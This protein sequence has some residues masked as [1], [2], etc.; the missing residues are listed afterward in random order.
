[1]APAQ[2]RADT[3]QQNERQE[4]RAVDDI[5]EGGGDADALSSDDFA[6]HGEEGAPE[7]GEGDAEDEPWK[8]SVPVPPDGL[9]SPWDAGQAVERPRIALLPIG[10]VVRNARNRKHGDVPSDAREMLHNLLTGR[11]QDAVSRAIDDLLDSL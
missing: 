2:E 9:G 1:M 11:A 5:E 7:R 10:N 6:E 3:H 4:E 8:A